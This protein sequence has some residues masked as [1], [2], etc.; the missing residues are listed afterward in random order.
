MLWLLQLVV[1][2][3][4]LMASIIDYDNQDLELSAEPRDLRSRAQ[5]SRAAAVS[6]ARSQEVVAN[7]CGGRNSVLESAARQQT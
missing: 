1:V 7:R 4:T 3:T 6:K 5:S 2:A